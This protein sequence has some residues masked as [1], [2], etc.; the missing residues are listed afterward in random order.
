MVLVA[1]GQAEESPGRARS[2]LAGSTLPFDGTFAG[3]IPGCSVVKVGKRTILTAAHCVAVNSISRDRGVS[4]FPVEMRVRPEYSEPDAVFPLASARTGP[5]RVEAFPRRRLDRVELHPTYVETARIRRVDD[6]HHGTAFARLLPVDAAT[7]FDV[8]VVKLAEDTPDMA[9]ARVDFTPVGDDEPLVKVGSGCTTL[10]SSP[11]IPSFFD[12]EYHV[13]AGPTRTFDREHFD[14]ILANGDA[15]PTFIERQIWTLQDDFETDAFHATHPYASLCTADSGGALLRHGRVV[16]VHVAS[17][18]RGADYHARLSLVKDWLKPLLCEDDEPPW[19]D[20]KAEC[21]CAEGRTW[22]DRRR[23]CEFDER[24][25]SGPD[26]VI[27]PPPGHAC[28][29][30]VLWRPSAQY[31]DFCFGNAW[32]RAYTPPCSGVVLPNGARDFTGC[33]GNSNMTN[34]FG[35]MAMCGTRVYGFRSIDSVRYVDGAIT[36]PDLLESHPCPRELAIDGV[37]VVPMSD[38]RVPLR[39]DH[40]RGDYVGACTYE[41]CGAPAD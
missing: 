39:D 5:R 28:R 27:E 40:F 30:V 8:A 19:N 23:I 32:N 25:A 33:L 26:P 36:T 12:P 16:G 17:S 37:R 21:V 1:C 35:A 24:P 9:V 13:L 41:I 7:P 31:Y 15:P 14:A 6:L 3:T 11:D 4:E 2:A 20:E 29:S 18:F 10:S 38:D 34:A 22:N